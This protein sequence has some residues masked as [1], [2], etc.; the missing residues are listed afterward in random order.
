MAAAALPNPLPS[1]KRFEGK[2]TIVTGASKGI[3]FAIAVRLA[4]EGAH[5]CLHYGR[6][7]AGA[8]AAE[9]IIAKNLEA[10]GITDKRTMIVSADM[11]KEEEVTAMFEA[12]F[13]EC[14]KLD[15]VSHRY[16]HADTVAVSPTVRPFMRS[17]DTT[18]DSE[19]RHPDAVSV[20]RGRVGGL[21][22][23]N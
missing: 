3:G 19:R 11:G 22:S 16:Q 5:V 9:A 1:A 12:Y 15:V 14:S 6:D 18:G 13:A 4:Q 2:Y 21:R 17:P 23:R 7:K 10:E 20:A 8:E